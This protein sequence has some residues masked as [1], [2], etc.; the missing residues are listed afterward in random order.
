LFEDNVKKINDILVKDKF[1]EIYNSVVDSALVNFEFANATVVK[2]E[3]ENG[4]VIY[5]NLSTKA[6]D[7]PVGK[8][9]PYEYKLG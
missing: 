8:L 3:F 6:S 5:T 7:S 1:I 9:Q 2:S 4:V